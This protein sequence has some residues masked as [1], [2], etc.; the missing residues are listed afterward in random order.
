MYSSKPNAFFREELALL[1][2]MSAD[3][4]YGI[5]TLRTRAAH[6]VAKRKL[7]FYA[8]H[9]ALTG[10]PNRVFL[11]QHFGNIA[12]PADAASISAA[13][14]LLDLDNCRS[15]STCPRSRSA[16]AICCKAL[17]MRCARRVSRRI[18][19]NSN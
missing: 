13:I 19:S 9:D 16:A 5:Q 4:A 10:T 18:A 15:R 14:L 1:E 12:M 3:L 17:P 6:E 2:E 7:E 11:R 8:H